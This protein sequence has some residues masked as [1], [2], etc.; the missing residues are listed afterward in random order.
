[1]YENKK[2]KVRSRLNYKTVSANQ[3][4]K[5]KGKPNIHE[6]LFS[7]NHAI[8]PK[9]CFVVLMQGKKN[10]V[11]TSIYVPFLNDFAESFKFVFH[12][13]K[14]STWAENSV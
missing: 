6:D 11:T 10:R 4:E 14:I 2:A 13:V 9:S 3:G 7:S 1:M 12:S 5:L 8:I